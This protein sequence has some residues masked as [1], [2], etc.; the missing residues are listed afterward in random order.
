ME[1]ERGT[2]L[3]EILQRKVE[4]GSLG[5]TEEELEAL[6]MARLEEILKRYPPDK[7]IVASLTVPPRVYTAR[8]LLEEIRRKTRVGRRLI[9]AEKRRAEKLVRLRPW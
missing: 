9:E 1:V 8:E 3:G 6:A 4:T 7:P 2:P 5:T